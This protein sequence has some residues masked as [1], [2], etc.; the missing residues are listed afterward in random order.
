[1]LLPIWCMVS[2]LLPRLLLDW[3]SREIAS[4]QE[5]DNAVSTL[6]L[7]V[8][9]PAVI[10]STGQGNMPCFPVHISIAEGPDLSRPLR[11]GPSR[12]LVKFWSSSGAVFSSSRK[13]AYDVT[14]C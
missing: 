12:L 13:E 9:T 14:F 2:S 4:F 5:R 3:S 7:V 10:T 6:L 11:D 8:T 1:M